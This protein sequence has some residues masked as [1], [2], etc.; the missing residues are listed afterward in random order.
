MIELLDQINNMECLGLFI[1]TLFL[2][3]IAFIF[4]VMVL[5]DLYE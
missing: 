5:K 2:M 3:A 4:L 1:A